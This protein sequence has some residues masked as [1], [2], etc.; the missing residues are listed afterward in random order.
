MLG[1]LRPV[2]SPE[3]GKKLSRLEAL[4]KARGREAD[5]FRKSHFQGVRHIPQELRAKLDL[6]LINK[7]NWPFD[8]TTHK[9]Y[10]S[11]KVKGLK[12]LQTGFQ[13]Y[14]K[15]IYK[16]EAVFQNIFS[17]CEIRFKIKIKRG[18]L[19]QKSGAEF[20]QKGESQI[21]DREKWNVELKVNVECASLLLYLGAEKSRSFDFV[22]YQLQMKSDHL[23]RV[24]SQ[25]NTLLHILY[26]NENREIKIK[27]QINWAEIE[28]SQTV[29]L[30]QIDEQNLQI[31]ISKQPDENLISKSKEAD[32]DSRIRQ[33]KQERW[34]E[35]KEK[36]KLEMK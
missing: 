20:N 23:E 11:P 22:L 33:L 16:G 6:T 31:T 13:T 17:T 12:S 30:V 10:I 1:K 24:I 5:G 3:A 28:R 14:Y 7:G 8:L 34:S 9:L 29:N 35:L 27:R 4:L 2:L 26:V 36:S 21:C 18:E 15:S 19:Q 32:L 25:I